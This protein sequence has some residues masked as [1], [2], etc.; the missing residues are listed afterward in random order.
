M[1]SCP[2]CNGGGTKS[3]PELGLTECPDCGGDGVDKTIRRNRIAYA[4]ELSDPYRQPGY[5]LTA[6]DTWE[7]IR[8]FAE[9]PTGGER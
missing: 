1:K 6:G 3:C 9:E 2:A 4:M 5:G 7:S 8:G